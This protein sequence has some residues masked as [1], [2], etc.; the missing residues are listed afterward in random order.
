MC[1]QGQQLNLYSFTGKPWTRFQVELACIQV[2][3]A[4]ARASVGVIWRLYHL[5]AEEAGST[6]TLPPKT[7]CEGQCLAPLP[8]TD[9]LTP[10]W[11][12]PAYL[13]LSSLN[14]CCIQY[15]QNVYRRVIAGQCLR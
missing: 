2:S 1:S 13:E 11:V 7:T 6:W 14:T 10:A 3:G 5:L 12:I 15:R 9:T 8:P 4:A